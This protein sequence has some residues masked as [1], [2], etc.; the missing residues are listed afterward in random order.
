MVG[1]L[2]AKFGLAAQT[3]MLELWIS[4]ILVLKSPRNFEFHHR[5]RGSRVTKRETKT[6]PK[7]V[8]LFGTLFLQIVMGSGTW[9]T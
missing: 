8:T 7:K 1:F 9:G 2:V 4:S 5:C 3:C 6:S